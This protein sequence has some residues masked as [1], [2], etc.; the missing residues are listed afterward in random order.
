MLNFFL[1]RSFVDSAKNGRLEIHERFGVREIHTGTFYQSGPYIK[2][3]WQK[4]LKSLPS[5]FGVHKILVLGL[6]GGDVVRLL[7]VEIHTGTFYQSGPYIKK[8]WQ[9]VLK[10]LP[11]DFGV[12]KILVLGFGDRQR[13]IHGTHWRGKPT[14]N[15]RTGQPRQTPTGSTIFFPES[16]VW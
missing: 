8:M 5:D 12:H 15:S 13:L 10:S 16:V 1:K 11:S 9:K 14:A 7:R 6:G 4:V 3:M 2:K